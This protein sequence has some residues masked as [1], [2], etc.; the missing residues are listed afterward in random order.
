VPAANVIPVETRLS[1]PELAAIPETY[2]TAWTALHDNLDLVPGQALL[3]R[4]ATSALG[5]AAVDLQSTRG[6]PCSR[7]HADSSAGSSFESWART[8]H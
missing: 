4:G 5:Q 8:R 1:W 3:V 7:R 2:A 6:R